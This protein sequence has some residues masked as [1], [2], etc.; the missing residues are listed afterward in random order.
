MQNHAPV[1]A[2]EAHPLGKVTMPP[3]AWVALLRFQDGQKSGHVTFHF[4]EG[5]IMQVEETVIVREGG[6]ATR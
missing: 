1:C 6:T 5:K 4:K 3:S 2:P